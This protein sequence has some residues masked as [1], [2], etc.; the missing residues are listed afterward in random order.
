MHKDV[1]QNKMIYPIAAYGCPVLK[2]V[3]EEIDEDYEGLK[4]LIDDMFETMYESAG[5]G[6]AAPQIS[7]PIRMFVIDA[8]P[9]KDEEPGLDGFK[10]VFINPEIVEESGEEWKFNEGC[11]SIPGIREDVS[12][13]P[14]VVVN[15]LD[16]DFNEIEEE[17]TGL[18]ARVIQ[19][20]FDHLEGI[21]FTDR[22]GALKKQLLKGKLSD[23]SKGIVDVDYKMKFPK[24]R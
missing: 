13:Q 8:S 20:E 9:F 5:V 12:R 15:Y 16:A 18:A 23:I 24:I 21:L 14:N 19:H 7:L 3:A 1:K 2:K 6:L 11:L 17:F 10:K 22:L 4:Q